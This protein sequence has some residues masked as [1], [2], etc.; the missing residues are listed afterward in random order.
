MHLTHRREK[1]LSFKEIAL[2]SLRSLG[3]NDSIKVR[4][5][6]CSYQLAAECAQ[7]YVGNEFT[8]FSFADARYS[9][10]LVL[11]FP[12]LSSLATGETTPEIKAQGL[13]R[14]LPK[15][16][17]TP[18]I[19]VRSLHQGCSLADR[20]GHSDDPDFRLGLRLRDYDW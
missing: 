5:L 9:P 6:C 1:A 4:A 11:F 13:P 17:K 19:W 7:A 20:F 10:H 12:R 14:Q 16:A 15:M 3:Q 18:H 2:H 8:R